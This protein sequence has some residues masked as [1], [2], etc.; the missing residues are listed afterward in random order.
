MHAVYLF[1]AKG[2]VK[3]DSSIVYSRESLLPDTLYKPFVLLQFSLSPLRSVYEK[4]ETKI[5]R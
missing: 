3:F 2:N 5:K 4:I 1:N